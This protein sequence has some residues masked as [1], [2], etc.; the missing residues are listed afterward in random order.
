MNSLTLVTTAKQR[1]LFFSRS[2]KLFL[3]T[4]QVIGLLLTGSLQSA[5]AQTGGKV[6]GVVVNDQG[7]PLANV[8]VV[9]KETNAGATTDSL[10]QFGISAQKGQTLVFTMTGYATKEWQL[11]N[12]NDPVQLT[13]STSAVS[14]DDVVVIGY[15]IRKKATIT[16]AVAAVT[17]KEVVTTKNENVQNMLTGKVAGLRVVQNSSE[18]GSFDNSFEIRGLGTPLVIIDGVPRNNITRLNPADIE[19]ISVLKDASAAIYGI[20]AANGVVL[21]TTK[22]GKKGKV[23]LNY[24][25]TY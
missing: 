4:L 16:G 1:E 23:S 21:I 15:G 19:S 3:F 13:L 11:S 8:S 25:G 7:N 20:R 17:G 18:P 9:V 14:L 24:N 6:H 5:I 22:K 2:R 12:E 10:G